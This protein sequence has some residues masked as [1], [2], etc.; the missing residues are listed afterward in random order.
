MEVEIE[1]KLKL[2]SQIN[3]RLNPIFILKAILNFVD[4]YF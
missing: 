3:K 4:S 2:A 1:N